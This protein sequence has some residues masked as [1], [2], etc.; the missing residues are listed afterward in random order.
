MPPSSSSA[1]WCLLLSPALLFCASCS[2]SVDV[3]VASGEDAQVTTRGSI[4]VTAKLLEIPEGAIFRRELYNYT[5]VLKYEIQQVHRGEVETATICV[6]HYNPFKTRAK[7]AD[8][9]V[10][11]IG[12]N[13]KA[14]RAG[15]VHR[16]ALE[17]PIEEHYMGAIVNKYFGQ[18]TG[19]IYWGVWTNLVSE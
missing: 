11:G 3:R 19:P 5:T 16:M 13:L 10:E 12:G 15:Q 18:E 4:E 2:R 1:G 17:V 9:R 8:R 6:G 7:A 14:F